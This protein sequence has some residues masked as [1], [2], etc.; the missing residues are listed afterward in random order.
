MKGVPSAQS[1]VIHMIST[2]V[3]NQYEVINVRAIGG[4]HV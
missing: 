2:A 1:M 3:K 4:S